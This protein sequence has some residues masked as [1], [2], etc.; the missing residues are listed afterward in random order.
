MASRRFG[1]KEHSSRYSLLFPQGST[2]VLQNLTNPNYDTTLFC[3][4]VNTV[5]NLACLL[6]LNP[7]EKRASGDKQIVYF[8]DAR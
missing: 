3:L 1:S 8:D 7:I 4:L 5:N 6:L 2:T